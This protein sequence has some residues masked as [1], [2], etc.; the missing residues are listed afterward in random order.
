MHLVGVS[1]KRIRRFDDGK[2]TK[3]GFQHKIVYGRV[4][5]SQ[6]YQGL[7]METFLRNCMK[8][9]NVDGQLFLN[10]AGALIAALIY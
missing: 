1:N 8:I 10:K 6:Q 4:T 3:V 5:K 9:K 7:S 2:Y